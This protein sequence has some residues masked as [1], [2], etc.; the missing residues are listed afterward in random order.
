[1]QIFFGTRGRPLF[2][3]HKSGTNNGRPQVPTSTLLLKVNMIVLFVM[4]KVKKEC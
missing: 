2:V 4:F 3:P 1:M